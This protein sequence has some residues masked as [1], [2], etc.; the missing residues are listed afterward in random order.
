MV[1]K[2]TPTARRMSAPA[3]RAREDGV[4]AGV[5]QGRPSL[6]CRNAP[7]LLMRAAWTRPE[8]ACRPEPGRRLG[9]QRA[10]TDAGPPPDRRVVL[11]RRGCNR[12][13]SHVIPERQPV[14]APA[15][16]GVRS[17]GDQVQGLHVSTGPHE[18]FAHAHGTQVGAILGGRG[19]GNDDESLVGEA[20]SQQVVAGPLRVGRVGLVPSRTPARRWSREARSLRCEIARA[21]R[22]ARSCRPTLRQRGARHPRER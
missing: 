3:Q 1:P 11:G 6:G 19:S 18:P 15:A 12:A 10:G 21:R 16:P 14:E 7:L 2:S 20:T 8:A 5:A 13:N 22:A 9:D 4:P 17:A